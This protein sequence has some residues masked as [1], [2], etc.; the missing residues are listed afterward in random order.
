MAL[1]R[2]YSRA[3]IARRAFLAQAVAIGCAARSAS[4]QV[5]TSATPDPNCPRCGGFGRIPL[6]DARPFVWLKGSPLPTGQSMAGEQFCSVCQPSG[7]A[8]A[9]VAEAKEQLEAAVAK[10]KQWEERMGGKLA[11]VVTRHATIHTQLMPAQARA[12]GTAVESL[13]LHLKKISGSMGLTV[14]RPDT[15]ELMLLW[16]KP[17]WEQFRKVMEGLYALEQLGESWAS[18]RQYNAYDHVAIPHMYETPQSVRT[19]PPACGAVFLVGRR[20]LNLATDWRA[21]FWLAEGFAAYSDHTVHNVNRWFTVYSVKQVPVGDWLGEARK[22]AADTKLRGWQEMVKREL[23]DWEAAD[24]E[25]SMAMV[26]FLV[27]TEPAKFLDLLRRLKSGD[28]EAAALEG[29]YRAKREELEE[30]F[31]RWLLAAK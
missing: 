17:A 5:T 16:E 8:A 27:E 22:L 18:A 3:G 19:R 23:R 10:S 12:V 21:P 7:N 26:A 9:I 25:Q 6:T 2:R 29:A 1:N 31:S 20:Q 24:H 28:N 30:R 14:T 13:T 4:G 15:L 11:C